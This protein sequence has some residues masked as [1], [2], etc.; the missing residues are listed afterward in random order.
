MPNDRRGKWRVAPTRYDGAL[1]LDGEGIAWI[2]LA[3]RDLRVVDVEGRLID[4]STIYPG[5]ESV[6]AA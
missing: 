3:P 5:F 2:R 1:C 4:S 6:P